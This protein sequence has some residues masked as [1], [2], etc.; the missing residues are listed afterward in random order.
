M[1]NR[2]T[3]LSQASHC[4]SL[5][6]QLMDPDTWVSPFTYSWLLHNNTP[7]T[8]HLLLNFQV[9]ALM[10]HAGHGNYDGNVSH[11]Q[12]DMSQQGNMSDDY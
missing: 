10:D 5:L 9:M 11:K 3:V 12:E 2:S 6:L 4:F 8:N 1:H 7:P